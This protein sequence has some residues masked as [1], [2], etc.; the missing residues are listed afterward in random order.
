MGSAA[1]AC[2]T[3]WSR[4]LALPIEEKL[5]FSQRHALGG[6]GVLSDRLIGSGLL[7]SLLEK[8]STLLE[9]EAVLGGR[10]RQLLHPSDFGGGGRRRG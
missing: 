2:L 7:C 1:D 6:G 9:R 10:N 4:D 5:S 3:G 8:I